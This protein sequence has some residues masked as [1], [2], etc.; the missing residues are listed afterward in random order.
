MKC[1]HKFKTISNASGG[2]QSKNALI[3]CEKCLKVFS[4]DPIDNSLNEVEINKGDF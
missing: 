3:Q 1:K 4:F 2:W